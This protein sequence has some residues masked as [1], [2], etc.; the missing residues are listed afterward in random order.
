L[1]RAVSLVL[2]TLYPISLDINYENKIIIVHIHL[3]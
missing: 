1:V 2:Y 3:Y